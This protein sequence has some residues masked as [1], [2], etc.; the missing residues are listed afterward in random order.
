MLGLSGAKIV[1]KGYQQMTKSGH[2]WVKRQQV[3]WNLVYFYEKI[4]LMPINIC[5]V[6]E[7]TSRQFT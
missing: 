3:F 7:A 1:C 4:K 5:S 2:W 6:Y